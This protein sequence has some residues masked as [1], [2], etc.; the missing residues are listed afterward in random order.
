MPYEHRVSLQQLAQSLGSDAHD[1]SLQGHEN[2][3]KEL[4]EL[5]SKLDLANAP[6]TPVTAVL[7][8]VSETHPTEIN[9]IVQMLVAT[10]ERYQDIIESD[11]VL[12]FYE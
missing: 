3:F 9:D 7:H 6:V 12:Q 10:E 8:D 1:Q 2:T 4:I 11:T 5:S